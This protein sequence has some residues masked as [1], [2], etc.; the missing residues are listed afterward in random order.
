MNMHNFFSKT[1]YSSRVENTLKFLS[2]TLF[3]IS[4]FGCLIIM[5]IPDFG[6]VI[7]IVSLFFSTVF[8]LCLYAFGELLSVLKQIRNTLQSQTEND[9]SDLP[10]I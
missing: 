4:I 9:Y 3:G 1:L 10:K 2:I 7:A 8:C 5:S 6:A